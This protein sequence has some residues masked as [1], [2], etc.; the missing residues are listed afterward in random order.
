[1]IDTVW[2]MVI[3][4]AMSVYNMIVA[5]T[6]IQSNI[7]EELLEATRID[8]CDDIG[9]F[10]RMVLPLSKAIISVLVLW[11][12]VGHWNA[13]FNAFLY[14]YDENLYPLQLFL[15][16]ILVNSTF[17]VDL[18]MDAEEAAQRP[19]QGTHSHKQHRKAQYKAQRGSQG[20]L[21]AAFAAPCE[22]G[23]INGQHGQQTRGYKGNDAL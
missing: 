12:A 10:F 15:R 23:D 11:Y 9:F 14:L 7:P 2:A 1:M 20:F 18:M 16:D 6:F 17:S 13:Y 5:R 8:G 21:G 3:P 22:V 4:G 19:R